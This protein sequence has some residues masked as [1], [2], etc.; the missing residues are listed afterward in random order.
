MSGLRGRK[1]R[2]K[3]SA[4]SCGLSGKK[5][6]IGTL[7]YQFFIDMTDGFYYD[8]YEYTQGV[9]IIFFAQNLND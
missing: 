8:I 7:Q 5:I 1:R 3:F 6:Q 2:K 4:F 9:A